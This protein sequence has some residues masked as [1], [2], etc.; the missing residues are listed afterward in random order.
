[1][2]HLVPGD[3]VKLAWGGN[4]N[5]ANVPMRVIKINYTRPGRPIVLNLTEDIF[6]SQV[7]AYADPPNSGW[8]DPA[9]NAVAV[10]L[11][12]GHAMEMPYAIAQRLPGNLDARL[13]Y[14]WYASSQ[15]ALEMVHRV[16]SKTGGD[17][18]E[19]DAFITSFAPV[20]TLDS[21]LGAG[22]TAQPSATPSEDIAVSNLGYPAAVGTTSKSL[23]SLGG[24]LEHLVL[25]G[26][27][28][29]L[30]RDIENVDGTTY[31]LKRVY[32]GVMDTARADHT[33]GAKV[34][35]L[36]GHMPGNRSYAQAA[37]VS[38]QFRPA[39]YSNI[40]EEGDAN[41][42]STSLANRGRRPYPPTEMKVGPNGS[43]TRYPTGTISLDSTTAIGSGV[44]DV[45]FDVEFWRRDYRE[46]DE[47]TSA[48]GDSGELSATA[49]K[50]RLTL[51]EDPDGTPDALFTSAWDASTGNNLQSAT[52]TDIL[53]N[54]DGDVPSGS[55]DDL[56]VEVETR[57]TYDSI[58]REAA[59]NETWAF[60]VSS[61][62]IASFTGGNNTGARATSI[63]SASMTATDNGTY[64]F[65]MG[66]DV[67]TSGK[68]EARINAGTWVDVIL[69]G[70]GLSGTLAGVATND[71]ITW[72]HTEASSNGNT[73]LTIDGP[74]TAKDGY[75]VL[76]T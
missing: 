52:R 72:R 5:I 36:R 71:L 33:A 22:A 38:S 8:T 19:E 43:T 14:L 62:F 59:I 11:D 64:T 46:Y 63:E 55:G 27:E 21:N 30:A 69:S 9:A 20:G 40:L 41:T 13:D 58:F 66:T 31:K 75:G 18:Y 4:L 53:A 70:D 1:M 26:S 51:T 39:T 54:N 44:D 49:T 65:T 23:G 37:T 2:A 67:L 50:Y 61:A 10:P 57:H 73:F 7:G 25:I 35:V 17:A 56:Q 42:E 32:R 48:T 28:L 24:N 6:G 74:S 76:I 47:I 16:W 29:M 45:G 68:L 34:F 15:Q 3:V 12:E 60:D